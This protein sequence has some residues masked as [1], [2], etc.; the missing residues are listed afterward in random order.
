[1]KKSASYGIFTLIIANTIF[2]TGCIQKYL[3][4]SQKI[5]ISYHYTT[6]GS[7]YDV[8]I[9]NSKI[10]FT[11]TDYAKIKEK[12]AQWVKQYP[13]WRQEDL[14]TEEAQLTNQEITDLKNLIE[15][16]KIMQLEN[17]YGPKKG[18]RCYSHILKIGKKKIIYCSRPGGFS[19]PEAFIKV[20]R[21]IKE[22]VTKKFSKIEY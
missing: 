12:C 20:S 11:H 18:E 2:I 22:I 7:Y 15:K 21:K 17:H 6:E 5:S 13:C 8:R 16:T 14:V 4:Q 10:T 3:N 19:P 1:M 9:E